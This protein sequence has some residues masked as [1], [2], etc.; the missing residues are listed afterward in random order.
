MCAHGALVW[1][2]KTAGTHMFLT[3]LLQLI[4]SF[5]AVDFVATLST[6]NL[7]SCSCSF[8]RNHL[9]PRS[10]RN[11]VRTEWTL[12][13]PSGNYSWTMW[14]HFLLSEL[15][16]RMWIDCES[17]SSTLWKFL[18]NSHSRIWMWGQG[19]IRAFLAVCFLLGREFQEWNF[20][21]EKRSSSRA[22]V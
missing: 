13:P 17:V 10:S 7:M 18:V 2:T 22:S 4:G 3:M 8:V 6:V 5:L 11:W 12:R 16:S 15:Q 14:V 19:I 21:S 20:L 9:V 1:L